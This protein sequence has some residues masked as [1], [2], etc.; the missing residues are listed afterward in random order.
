LDWIIEKANDYAA[1]FSSAEEGLLAEISAFTAAQHPEPHMLSGHVQGRVLAL[2]S[3]MIRPARVLEIGT[4]TGYS[5]L[6]LAEGMAETGILHTIEKRESDA[7][8]ASAYFNR[9]SFRDRIIQHVGEALPLIETLNEDWDLLFLDADKINYVLYYEAVL[10]K[11]R[12]GGF[13][14]ADNV[15]FH[16]QVLEEEVKGKS[17]K[18]IHAFNQHVQADPRT[19][20]VLMTV[21][22]GL[23][24]IRK[25]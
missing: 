13:L 7:I 18:A 19:E 1:A 12:S 6:C 4:M 11:M 17:A 10:P 15:L 9:S 14:I 25:K 22:D 16:G 23:M 20:N 2:L 24:L 5:A 3:A 8:T 21:R